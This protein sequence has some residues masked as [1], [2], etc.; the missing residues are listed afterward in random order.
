MHLPYFRDK[1]HQLMK[2]GR[3]MYPGRL[4]IVASLCKQGRFPGEEFSTLLFPAVGFSFCKVILP[5]PLKNLPARKHRAISLK[6]W[7]GHLY[8]TVGEN[9]LERLSCQAT[10]GGEGMDSEREQ[11]DFTLPYRPQ[12]YLCFL[13]EKLLKV[14][15]TFFYLY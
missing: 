4:I 6:P 9:G 2:S 11:V 1:H 5:L 15:K 8:Y 10:V 12:G 14:S 13:T 3:G 7:A